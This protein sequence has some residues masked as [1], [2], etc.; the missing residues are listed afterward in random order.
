MTVR[1]NLRLRGFRPEREAEIAGRS[2]PPIGRRM[3]EALRLGRERGAGRRRRAAAH[4]RLGRSGP[5]VGGS[6]ERKGIGYDD[7]AKSRGRPRS[8]RTRAASRC[9]PA[10]GGD[11]L[12]G[13]R[14]LGKNSGLHHRG[15]SDAGAV[16]RRQHRHI[17]HHQ[18]GHVQVAAGPRSA[19][20][21]LLKWSARGK[22]GAMVSVPMEIATD[23]R[24]ASMS[25]LLAVQTVPGRSAGART[26]FRASPSSPGGG[27]LRSAV[28]SP[29]IRPTGNTSRRLFSRRSVWAPPPD[30]CSCR[31]MMRPVR[32]AVVVLQYAYWK[33]QFVGDVKMSARHRPERAAVHRSGRSRRIFAYLTP[34]NIRDLF[35]ALIPAPQS[36]AGLRIRGRPRKE[37]AGSFLD[38]GGGPFETGHFG[39]LGAEPAYRF[40]PEQPDA[41]RKAASERRRTR[42]RFTLRPGADRL[43]RA[44]AGQLSDAAVRV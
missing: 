16:H 15:G 18:R 39:G 5:G 40:V 20:L 37:D 36:P 11:V 44:S 24:G 33:R 4:R 25:T 38:C 13:L 17:Q 9:L 23:S 6:A 29:Y 28:W 26:I 14:V 22:L 12:Y 41:C 34:G 42:P 30:A 19:A 27:R 32:R 3:R 8:A 21:M 31:P 35:G 43:Y 7:V 1:G 10:C 2:G